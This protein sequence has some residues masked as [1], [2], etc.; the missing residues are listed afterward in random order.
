M[1]WLYQPTNRFTYY[2]CVA[3]TRLVG[4]SYSCRV[5]QEEYEADDDDKSLMGDG[6]YWN[7]L[8]IQLLL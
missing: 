3:L 7:G 5:S 6:N 2:T 1:M 4:A 8:I